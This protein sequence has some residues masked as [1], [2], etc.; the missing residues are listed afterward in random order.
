MKSALV[1]NKKMA[2]MMGHTTRKAAYMGEEWVV[3]RQRDG[4]ALE[5]RAESGEWVKDINKALK[6]SD[7]DARA[8][9]RTLAKDPGKEES[10]TYGAQ[11]LS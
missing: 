9:I 11:L 3:T 4:R 5:Y 2:I 6:L 10:T 8:H 7:E 1:R